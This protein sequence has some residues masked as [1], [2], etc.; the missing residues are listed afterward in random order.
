WLN[1]VTNTGSAPVQV[2][3][4]LRGLIA[5]ANQTKITGTSSG[6][7]LNAGTNW[8]TTSQIVPQGTHSLE[9]KLGFVVQNNAGAPT[10]ATSAGINSVGQAA[11]TFMPTIQPGATAIVMT[12]VTVQGKTKQ[13]T[14]V[15]EN[16]VATPLPADTITCM[17]EQELH[18]VVNFP[19]VT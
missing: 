11:F 8:F 4:T 2:G 17:S 7:T 14:N 16:I 19:P 3:I 15:C 6:S 13:A 1:M 5:S 10:P 12:F 9:P 18:D